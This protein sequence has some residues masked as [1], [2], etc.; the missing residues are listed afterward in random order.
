M[1]LKPPPRSKPEFERVPMYDD[2]IKGKIEDI[3]FNAEHKSTWN[4]EEKIR[5]AVRFKFAL[6]GCQF[7]HRTGWMTF[8]YGEKTTLFK[9]YITALVKDAQPDMDFDLERLKGLEVKTMWAQNGDYDNLEM[10]RPMG[11]KLDPAIPF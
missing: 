4:G 10:V 11:E 6:D 1:A 2:W 9:K 7:A 3:E 8:S 5:P